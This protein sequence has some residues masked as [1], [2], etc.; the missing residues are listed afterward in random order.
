MSS[1][2]VALVCSHNHTHGYTTLHNRFPVVTV[3]LHFVSLITILYLIVVSHC[4][5]AISS[6]STCDYHVVSRLLIMLFVSHI[7]VKKHLIVTVRLN[8]LSVIP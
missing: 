8:R 5:N 7:E 4:C 1:T 3:L 6:C 2:V